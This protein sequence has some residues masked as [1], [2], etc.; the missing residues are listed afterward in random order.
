M[1]ALHLSSERLFC[2]GVKFWKSGCWCCWRLGGTRRKT[3][4]SQPTFHIIHGLRGSQSASYCTQ[5]IS[6]LFFLLLPTSLYRLHCSTPM[7]SLMHYS[8]SFPSF[9]FTWSCWISFS[10]LLRF[11]FFILIC[12][13]YSSSLCFVLLPLLYLTIFSSQF[14][15]LYPFSS[16]SVSFNFILCFSYPSGSDRSPLTTPSMKIWESYK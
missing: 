14:L 3:D 4:G 11:F 2:S 7:S 15:F 5:Y 16:F 9:L 12:I 6:F 1:Y 8:W 10:L 13:L